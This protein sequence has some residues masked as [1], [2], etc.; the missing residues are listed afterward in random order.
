M[1]VASFLVLCL[2]HMRKKTHS[3][4]LPL[5]HYSPLA[6][7]INSY[8]NHKA[9]LSIRETSCWGGRVEGNRQEMS[10]FVIT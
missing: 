8:M 6:T 2:K 9:I 4:N 7:L 3:F 5:P 10:A 1:E